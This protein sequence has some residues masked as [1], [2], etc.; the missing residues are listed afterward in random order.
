MNCSTP[1]LPVYHQL[2]E[3]T[4]TLVHNAE[5]PDLI[6]GSGRSPREGIGYPLW[7]SWAPLVAQSIKNP[8]AMWQTYNWPQPCGLALASA[9]HAEST[10]GP[11]PA[12]GSPRRHDG[13]VAPGHNPG[14]NGWAGRMLPTLLLGRGRGAGSPSTHVSAHPAAMQKQEHAGKEGG[15]TGGAP[16][17]QKR[18]REANPTPQPSS[19]WG[20]CPR[21]EG[22]W[23]ESIMRR[24]GQG[25]PGQSNALGDQRSTCWVVG[26]EGL[27][28]KRLDWSGGPPG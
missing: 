4:Q 13:P 10:R 1:G 11:K 2:P 17:R 20:S 8:P 23:A 26:W 22:A 15:E 21:A 14:L 9:P 16:L 18:A 28:R 7:Y 5:D 27:G 19:A 6:S 12:R 25:S 3:F 24:P